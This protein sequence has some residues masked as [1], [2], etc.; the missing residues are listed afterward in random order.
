M[1]ARASRTTKQMPSTAPAPSQASV[2]GVVQS[3]C[4]AWFRPKTKLKMAPQPSNRPSAS[5]VAWLRDPWRT[6]GSRLRS[7]TTKATAAIATLTYRHQRQPRLSVSAPPMSRPAAA[8]TPAVAPSTAKA[9]PRPAPRGKV[10][11]TSAMSV[12]ASN[13]PNPPWMARATTST[14]KDGAKPAPRLA[15][16]K[17]ISPMR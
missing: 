6:V 10:T 8:P 2:D 14:E 1:A 11:L 16:A 15:A 5:S 3:C 17:P 4:S 13:A 7:P 9:R 12:G